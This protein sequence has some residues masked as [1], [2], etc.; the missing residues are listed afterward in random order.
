MT[1]EPLHYFS[2]AWERICTKAIH[3][4]LPNAFY[5]TIFPELSDQRFID[6]SLPAILST[7]EGKW[8]ANITNP[9]ALDFQG[10]LLEEK[11]QQQNPQTNT[12]IVTVT[13]IKKDEIYSLQCLKETPKESENNHLSKYLA[14]SIP[15]KN[16]ETAIPPEILHKA[17][18][19]LSDILASETN[20]TSETNKK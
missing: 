5:A 17:Y 18:M 20:S 15:K 13:Y 10:I 1:Q 16:E 11:V 8:R 19:E 12:S 7:I 6:Q 14:L 3:Q 9:S 2:Q 4:G